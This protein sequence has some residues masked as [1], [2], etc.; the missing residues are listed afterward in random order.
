MRIALTGSFLG[1]GVTFTRTGSAVPSITLRC[2][3]QRRSAR[4]YRNAWDTFFKLP[5]VDVGI[6]VVK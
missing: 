6:V 2:Y 1:F 4:W 3:M 5:W